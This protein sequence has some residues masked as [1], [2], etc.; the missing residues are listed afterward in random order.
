VR[1][2]YAFLPNV[3]IS[4]HDDLNIRMAELRK[5][6]PKFQPDPHNPNQHLAGGTSILFSIL[7]MPQASTNFLYYQKT[8]SL[9]GIVR[10]HSIESQ[11]YQQGRKFY[12]YTP[13]NYDA[14]KKY[15]ML[16]LL[17][18]Q[19]YSES[20]MN[21]SLIL[22]NLIAHEKINPIIAIFVDSMNISEREQDLLL[23]E[24]LTKFLEI[25]LLPMINNSYSI[26]KDPAKHIIAGASLGGTFALYFAIKNPHL[27]Q[28]ILIN[29]GAFWCN[30]KKLEDL[31]KL[32]NKLNLKIYMDYGS[33]EDP[34]LMKEL[35]LKYVDKLSQLGCFIKSQEFPGGHNYYCWRETIGEALEF[36]VP[37]DT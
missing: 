2:A 24:E 12:I 17:D 4:W 22:D 3:N 32:M 35:N 21:L 7:E 8:E 30:I 5:L 13:H 18:G 26:A 6:M 9:K 28:N 34:S 29:S 1:L 23:S 20:G 27:F 25:E 14:S 31:I 10:S 19:M 15:E 36:L 37:I 11:I 16:L 33:L